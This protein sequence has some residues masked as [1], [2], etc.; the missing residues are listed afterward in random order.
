VSNLNFVKAQTVPNLVIAPV[1]A[2]GKVA[3][4]N[5]SAGSVQLV[6]DVSGYYRATAATPGPVTGVTA[7]PADTS[8][9][10]RW[11]NPVSGSFT[12]VMI[13]R[14]VGS[15]VPATPTSGSFVADV[16]KPTATFTNTGMLSG[17]KYTYAL[18]AHDAAVYAAAAT[19]T[20]TTTAPPGPVTGVTATADNTSVSLSWVNP[21]ASSLTG[22]MIRRAVGSVA[23][24][25]A[26]AGT[27]VAD[28]AKPT[29]VYTD[30]G[31]A[32]STRYSYALFAHDAA[33]T[34]AVAATVS[35]T[36]APPGPVTGVFATAANTSVTLHW[37]NPTEQSLTGVMI[38]RAAGAVAPAS[39]SAGTLVA[40]VTKPTAVYTDTGLASSTQYSYALFAHDGVPTFA[41]VAT[42]T[43]TTT[44]PPGPVTGVSATS[45]NTSVSLSWVNP[46]GS[47]LTGVMIRRAAG[48]VA[49]ASASAGTLVADVTK[50]TAG[51]TDTGLTPATQ[52]SYALFAHDATPT[53]ATAATVTVSTTGVTVPSIS[54]TVTDAGGVHH[55]LNNVRV[56]VIATYTAGYGVS[57]STLVGGTWSVVGLA[58]GTYVVCFFAEDATGGSSD[59]AGYV[60]QC[61]KN[62]PTVQTATLVTVTVGATTSGIDAALVGV[63]PPS[64]P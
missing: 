64:T 18:F 32:S 35:V 60:D 47:S 16:A 59:A 26:N 37:V 8:V 9:T 63:V 15:M 14:S 7:T 17:T 28:V 10:L 1:G 41:A 20:A 58:A 48:A 36:T 57:S 19:V 33:R 40:D 23:P 52:Y 2:Y 46:A 13:R 55:G 31:L 4:Y 29:A 11:V 34:Y 54:G 50:P 27:L 39:A 21:A 3:L 62:Q 24:A 49:P 61:Y 30:T 5:G 53:Y 43:A 56:D 51:Y 42:V 22:V 44:A 12:G 38:R 25:S 45:A 6:A